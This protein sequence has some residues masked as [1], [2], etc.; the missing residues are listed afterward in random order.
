MEGLLSRGG[1]DGDKKGVKLNFTK[2]LT[3][4]TYPLFLSTKS[5]VLP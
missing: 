4:Y 1:E 2:C 5:P 3:G